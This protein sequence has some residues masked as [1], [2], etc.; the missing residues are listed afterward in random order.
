MEKNRPIFERGRKSSGFVPAGSGIVLD[1]CGAGQHFIVNGESLAGI[2]V[3]QDIELHS[4]VE[5]HE[6]SEYLCD[7]RISTIFTKREGSCVAV[8]ESL[9]ARW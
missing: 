3:P 7:A 5:S 4:N 9:F 1:F 2:G 8:T 6:V